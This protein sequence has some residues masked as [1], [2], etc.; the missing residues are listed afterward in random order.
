M[1]P[2]NVEYLIMY[3]SIQL[4]PLSQSPSHATDRH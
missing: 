1:K 2:M 3:T 4:S